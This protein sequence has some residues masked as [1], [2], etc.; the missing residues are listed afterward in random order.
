[1]YLNEMSELENTNSIFG[2]EVLVGK[3]SYYIKELTQFYNNQ[4]ICIY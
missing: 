3:F 1:M 2:V 4:T